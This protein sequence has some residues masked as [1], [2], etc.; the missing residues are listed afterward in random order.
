MNLACVWEHNG[1]DTLLY[2]RDYPGVYARGR[3]LE[4]A[5]GKLPADMQSYHRWCS[6]PVPEKLEVDVVQNLSSELNIRDADSDALLEGEGKAL[7]PE[8]YLEQKALV[9][10]SAEDFLRLYQ[11][12]PDK[13]FPLGPERKTFYGPV[14][15]TAESMYLHTK[16]VNAYYFGEIG[17]ETDNEGD[18]L[19]C[20]LRG[21]KR[22]ES[23]PD[24]QM[25]A[26][27]EGS[28]GELWSL[29]KVLRRFLWHDR[30]HAKALYRRAAAVFGSEAIPDVF[31]FYTKEK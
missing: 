13:Q 28:Y 22:M 6:L 11:S 18:I 24:F 10:R 20:R 26:V 12:I 14:P 16:N 1:S 21:F 27:V 9:L 19:E 7:S 2:A 3:T 5:T 31:C 25:S 23:I 29:R 15:N 30:I 17:V 8:E 4:E